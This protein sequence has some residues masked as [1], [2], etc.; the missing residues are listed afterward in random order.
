[1]VELACNIIEGCIEL[2]GFIPDF[3]TTIGALLLDEKIKLEEWKSMDLTG[4][5]EG[6]NRINKK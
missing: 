1:M 5:E 6:R 4:T 2:M 3:F